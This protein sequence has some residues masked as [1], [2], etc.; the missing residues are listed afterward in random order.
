MRGMISVAGRLG[1]KSVRI[2]YA[3][4]V[5]KYM[6]MDL[7]TNTLTL[8]VDDLEIDVVQLKELQ[9]FVRPYVVFTFV[10]RIGLYATFTSRKPADKQIIELWVAAVFTLSLNPELDHYV[11]LVKDDPP[12]AEVL[13]IDP[14]TG[15]LSTIKVE[16]TQHG[17]HSQNVFDVIGKKLLKRYQ[18]G[19]VLVVFVEQSQN[20]SLSDLQNFLRRNNPYNQQIFLIGGGADAG[21]FKIVSCNDLSSPTPDETARMEMKVDAKLASKGHRAYVG[22]SFEPRGSRRL[23]RV[24][25]QYPIFVKKITLSR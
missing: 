12:D 10:N 18:D 15:T 8:F 16:I 9:Y 25:P 6:N 3:D 11:R 1:L 24:F 17:K 7:S 22:V 20:L 19:T 14:K 5:R 23:G 21:S 2:A 4:E 13:M